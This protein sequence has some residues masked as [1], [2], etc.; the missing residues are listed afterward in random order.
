MKRVSQE[1]VVVERA[2]A[3][4]NVARKY[5]QILDSQVETLRIQFRLLENNP[6]KRQMLARELDE[7]RTY[8]HNLVIKGLLEIKRL[9]KDSDPFDIGVKVSE[10][11]L[12]DKDELGKEEFVLRERIGDWAARIA[13][14]PVAFNEAIE[15]VA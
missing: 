3:V 9:V 8:Y 1:N 15:M 6:H 5:G 11:L 12:F 7:E 4:L 13:F 10:A 14:N 2:R